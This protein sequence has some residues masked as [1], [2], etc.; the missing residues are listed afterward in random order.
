MNTDSHRAFQSPELHKAYDEGKGYWGGHCHH[1]R[2]LAHLSHFTGVD[3]KEKRLDY[4]IACD[5]CGSVAHCW[6]KC[7]GLKKG[8]ERRNTE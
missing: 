7:P 3:K 5:F 1:C 2:E 6:H 8:R 4:G